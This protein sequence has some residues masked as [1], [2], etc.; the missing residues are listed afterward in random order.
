M[1]FADATHHDG[2]KITI[3]VEQ[4]VTLESKPAGTTI[5][6]TNG[7]IV[8]KETPDEILGRNQA[9]AETSELKI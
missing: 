4:I 9:P 1:K 3:N 8:V 7:L 6:L 2:S 5:V